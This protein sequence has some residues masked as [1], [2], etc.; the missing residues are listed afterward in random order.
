MKVIYVSNKVFTNVALVLIIVA[1]SILY[2]LGGG[3]K[4]LNVFLSTQKEIP[5][6]SVDTQE[7]KIAITFDA[8]NGQEYTD[9]ILS[10]LDKNNVKATFFTLGIFVDKYPQKLK[11]I[12]AKGHEIGNH[13]NN[14]IHFTQLNANEMKQEIY[15][16]GNKIF[17]ITGKKPE[18]FRVPFGDFNSEVVKNVKESGCYCIQ[19]DVDSLDYK[20][21]GVQEIYKNVVGKV[22]NGSII[23]FHINSEQTPEAIDRIIKELKKENYKFVTVSE[24]IYR[25]GYYI[26]HT[27]RQRPIN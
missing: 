23:L 19:W 6:H 21:P 1:V 26:D 5:I 24:L 18:L 8:E 12:E 2:S 15:T 10:V 17:E 14:N 9:K 27:G 16:G 20:N 22:Q 4:I 13:S 11:A 25:D 7:K 3:F